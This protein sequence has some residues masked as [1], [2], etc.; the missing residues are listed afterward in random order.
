M[1]DA[2]LI[3]HKKI[4]RDTHLAAIGLAPLIVKHLS[5]LSKTGRFAPHP[6]QEK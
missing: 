6:P 3:S 2:F 1:V 5:G 4:H